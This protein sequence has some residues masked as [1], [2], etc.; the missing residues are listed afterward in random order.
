MVY[1]SVPA[2]TD[3]ITGFV[4]GQNRSVVTGAATIATPA[5]SASHVA[6]G[7]YPINISA[8]T[9][10]APNYTFTTFRD[11]LLSITPAAL[12]VTANNATKVYGASLPVLTARITGF[13][14]GDSISVVSGR[15]A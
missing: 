15:R 4:Y 10:S 6:G 8:G 3:Q 14:N 9:L 11:G 2:L 13:A 5:T 1:G 12:T 7:P